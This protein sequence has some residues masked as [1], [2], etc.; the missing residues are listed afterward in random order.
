MS[1]SAKVSIVLAGL[2]LLAAAFISGGGIYRT[3]NL[4]YGEAYVVNRFTGSVRVLSPDEPV[5]SRLK[6][7]PSDALSK[8]DADASLWS[9]GEQGLDIGLYNGSSWALRELVVTLDLS[10]KD[11]GKMH[12]RYA[13]PCEIRPL[14]SGSTWCDLGFSPDERGLDRWDWDIHSARGIPRR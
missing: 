4:G 13:V 11:G 3:V 2:L 6:E 10:F 9:G 14:S 7:L 8:L 1:R 12:R 5:D